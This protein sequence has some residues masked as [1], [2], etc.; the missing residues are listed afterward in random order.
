MLQMLRQAAGTWVAKILLLLL[1]ASF[2]VWGIAGRV[3]GGFGEKVVVAGDASASVTDYRLAYDRQIMTLSRQFGQR[4]TREQARS[5]GL[6]DR[7]LAEVVSG[8]LLDAQAADLGLG[9]SRQRLAQIAGE[10]PTFAGPDGRFDRRTF[11]A[12]LR[13]VGMRPEDYLR[14]QSQVAIRQQI[15]S[16]MADGADIPDTF[17]SAVALYRGER[18]NADYIV[19]TPSSLPDPEAPSEDELAKWYAENSGRF[20][21]PEYRSIS[22]IVLDPQAIADPEAVSDEAVA[23]EYERTKS[24]YGQPERRTVQQILYPDRAAAEAALA[25]LEGDGDFDTLLADAGRTASQASLGSVARTDIPDPAIA[26]AAFSLDGIGTTGIVE[27]KFG[28]AILRVT[29]VTPE[30]VKPLSEVSDEVRQEMALLEAR[31][32]LLDRYDSYEDARAGGATLA[33]AAEKIGVPVRRIEA[34]DAEGRGPDGEPIADLPD[35]KGLLPDVFQ[36]E[37]G[38]ENP[39][40]NLAGDGFVFYEVNAITPTRARPL[41]EVREEALAAYRRAKAATA[42]ADLATALEERLDKGAELASIAAELGLSV[43]HVSDLKRDSQVEALG[44]NAVE[45]IFSVPEGEA[46]Q[47]L[48]SGG[49]DHIVFRVTEVFRPV[50]SGADAV[51]PNEQESFDRAVADDLLRQLVERLQTVYEP[52]I[53]RGAA[54]RALS[55]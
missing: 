48:A 44:A 33:E 31:N 50:A 43:Q 16:A 51:A 53:D 25:K 1:V 32:D 19:L 26:D 45:A 49:T 27:G 13:E 9:L 6:D 22:L 28:P 15:V 2:A 29:A 30:S 40:E 4:V 55:F 42:V 23:D 47:V 38:L 5:L 36:A 7:A 3:N 46:G 18:R 12:V 10:D 41:E 39:A 37:E 21:A 14:S 24:R 17:L 54:Q 34:I 20:D 11:D 52:R 35:A 8:T